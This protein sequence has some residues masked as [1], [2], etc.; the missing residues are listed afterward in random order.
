MIT[1][2]TPSMEMGSQLQK[3]SCQILLLAVFKKIWVLIPFKTVLSIMECNCFSFSRKSNQIGLD[4]H[5]YLNR[6]NSTCH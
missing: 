2:I 4:S 6:T 5:L 3:A 1:I